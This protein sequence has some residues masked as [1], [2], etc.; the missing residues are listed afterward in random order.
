MFA[1]AIAPALAAEPGWPTYGGDQ[2]GSRFSPAHQITP[3]NIDGL[4]RE[5]IYHTGDV[6]RRPPALIKRIKFETTPILVDDKLVLCSSFNEVIA[7]DP[8]SGR[9][10]WRYDPKV[11]ADIAPVTAS[12]AAA[13]RSGAIPLRHP[14]QR[15]RCV[16][17][18]APSTA[19]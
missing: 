11:A 8:A 14:V 1:D 9:Q 16:S 12:T 15:A 2:A 19:D 10:L 17:S 6:A 13:S 4:R 3:A 7:L 5:W 18:A